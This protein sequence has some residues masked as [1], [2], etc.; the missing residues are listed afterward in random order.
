MKR[1]S[2]NFKGPLPSTSKNKYLL[3][4]VDEYSRFPF[5]FACSYTES[6][7]VSN[8]LQQILCLLGTPAYVHSDLGKSFISSE[9]ISF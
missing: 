5:A 2:I 4:V 1:L 9:V 8:C 6:Q 3:T 7:T